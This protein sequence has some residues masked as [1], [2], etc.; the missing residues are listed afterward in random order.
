MQPIHTYLEHTI[1]KPT[2]VQ[3]DIEQLIEDALKYHFV[4][5]CIPPYWV[6]K[7]KRDLSHTA[8]QVVT[9]V[10]FPLGYQM[11]QVKLAEAQQAIADGADEIDMVMNIS[12]FKTNA[13]EWVK[14]ELAAMAKLCHEHGRLLKVIIETAYL[15]EAEIVAAC[16]LCADAGADYVKTSTGFAP[17]GAKAEHIRLMRQTVGEGLGVKA[18]GGVRN[19]AQALAMVK[20]G[21]DRIGTSA[22][23]SICEEALQIS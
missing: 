2:L 3:A 10:G 5:V 7:V 20:A 8:I 23:P 12:A 21:A 11:T 16:Q 15:N 14:P 19:Y 1:L 18:S 22:G 6:R 4:G 13:K 17:E 9:V